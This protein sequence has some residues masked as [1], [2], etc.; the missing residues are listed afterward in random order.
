MPQTT[1]DLDVELYRQATA[2]AKAGNQRMAGA[3]ARLEQLNLELFVADTARRELQRKYE[4]LERAI[5]D[6]QAEETI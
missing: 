5:L 1:A 6:E 2:S 3:I 4:A